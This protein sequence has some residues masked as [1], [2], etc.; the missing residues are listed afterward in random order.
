MDFTNAS[1]KKIATHIVGNKL[2]EDGLKLTGELSHV[3][4]DTQEHILNYFLNPFKIEEYY[5]FS[6]SVDLN[7]NTVFNLTQK[8]FSNNDDFISYSQNIAKHLYEQAVHP[9]IKMGELHVVYFSNCR[10]ENKTC[11]AIGIFKTETKDVFLKF[12]ATEKHLEIEHDNGVALTKLDKGC[13]IFNTEE[14]KGFKVM[15]YDNNGKGEEAQY[16]K[17]NFLSLKACAD[18]F[19][20]TNNYLKITKDFV[21]KQLS[22]EFEVNKTDSID[23]LNKSVGYFK[24]SEN[25]NEKEFAKEVFNNPEVIESFKKFKND[26]TQEYDISLDDDFQISVAAVKKQARIF[27]SV[28][29]LDK[30][31]HVYIHGD[32]D[33]IEKGTDENGR[34]FYKIYY[35]EE[36]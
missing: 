20:F 7:L 23:M 21:T 15:V 28:L 10:V 36:S 19:H 11:D 16:W 4:D 2:N 24:V 18:E 5:A 8:V 27:K 33:L 1:I 34:K 12:L 14:K 35:N 29:K 32:K 30:N 17:N 13:I 3:N 22:D 26:Y 25:F 31:F 9:K 6:N